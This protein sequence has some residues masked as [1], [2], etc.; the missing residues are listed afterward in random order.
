MATIQTRKRKRKR[1]IR[2]N[3]HPGHKSIFGEIDKTKEYIIYWL[4][5]SNTLQHDGYEPS[6]TKLRGIVDYLQKISDINDIRKTHDQNIFLV[7]DSVFLAKNFAQ[8]LNYNQIR[9]IYVY[10]ENQAELFTE[11]P[12]VSRTL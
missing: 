10:Q 3:K 1:G 12:K 7:L 4:P 2:S 11:C 5:D 6:R 8:L 9:L